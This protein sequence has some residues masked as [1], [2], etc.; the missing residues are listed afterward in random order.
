MPRF[1]RQRNG[2]STGIIG[3]GKGYIK[4]GS[5]VFWSRRPSGGCASGITGITWEFGLF[6]LPKATLAPLANACVNFPKKWLN[7]VLSTQLALYTTSWREHWI[8]CSS[9]CRYLE[10]VGL[11]KEKDEDS[12]HI[13]LWCLNDFNSPFQTTLWGSSTSITFVGLRWAYMRQIQPS[14]ITVHLGQNHAP[15][16]DRVIKESLLLKAQF[17]N[18]WGCGGSSY[19]GCRKHELFEASGCIGEVEP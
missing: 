13:V 19:S 9:D 1:P 14:T 3:E 2:E 18:A 5:R 12:E 4:E 10:V 11:R 15:S 8:S 6:T 16:F 17:K 7:L